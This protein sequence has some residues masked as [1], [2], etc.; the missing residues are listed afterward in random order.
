MM[1]IQSI[2]KVLAA[3]DENPEVRLQWWIKTDED[4]YE[5]AGYWRDVRPFSLQVNLEF[6]AAGEIIRV[7]P[8]D[9]SDICI[10]N[11]S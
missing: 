4:G 1:D 8:D 3:L 5:I 11:C 6:I 10:P 2:I 7:K 9:P